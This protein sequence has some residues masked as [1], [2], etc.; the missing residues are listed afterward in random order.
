MEVDVAAAWRGDA[1]DVAGGASLTR[2]CDAI[3]V[4]VAVNCD[5]I[6]FLFPK[7]T[8]MS[9]LKVSDENFLPN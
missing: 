1:G 2:E 8:L 6:G 5:Q 7:D 4:A 3:A 9:L